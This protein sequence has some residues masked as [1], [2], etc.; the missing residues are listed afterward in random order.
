MNACQLTPDC[1]CQ[2]CHS[3]RDNYRQRFIKWLNFHPLYSVG[4][5]GQRRGLPLPQYLS[6][7]I[8]DGFLDRDEY[9]PI[10]R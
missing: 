5:H 2:Q 1:Q 8:S 9:R 6:E 7:E 4:L 3:V 10:T